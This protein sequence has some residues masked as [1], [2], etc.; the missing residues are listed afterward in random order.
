MMWLNYQF[1]SCNGP[2][3]YLKIVRISLTNNYT[4][5]FNAPTQSSTQHLD[6]GRGF[7]T[8]SYLKMTTVVYSFLWRCVHCTWQ[9]YFDFSHSIISIN[10]KLILKSTTLNFRNLTDQFTSP[11]PIYK[12]KVHHGFELLNMFVCILFVLSLSILS[13]DLA[14]RKNTINY[15]LWPFIILFICI[16]YI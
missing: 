2:L 1:V 6:N 13:P 10:I 3:C 8:S 12:T 4:S 5:R 14:V 16:T 11:S 15:K 7:V 9:T